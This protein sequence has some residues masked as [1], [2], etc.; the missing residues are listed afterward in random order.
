MNWLLMAQTLLIDCGKASKRTQGQFSG[1]FSEGGTAPFN[2]W[3]N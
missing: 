3:N 1:P 2:R